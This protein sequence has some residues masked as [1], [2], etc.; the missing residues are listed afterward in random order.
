MKRV[1]LIAISICSATF[2]LVSMGCSEKKKPEKEF[3]DSPFEISKKTE[4][5]NDVLNGTTIYFDAKNNSKKLVGFVSFEAVCYDSVGI[6]MG[7]GG[8]NEVNIPA[9]A[10]R[11]IEIFVSDV[12]NPAKSEIQVGVVRYE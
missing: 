6:L 4:K 8:T 2:L 3:V 10:S 9:G 5:L 11:V 7:K 1:L 12:I